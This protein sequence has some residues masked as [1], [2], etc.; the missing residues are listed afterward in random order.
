M[1]QRVVVDTSAIVSI[2][3]EK[4]NLEQQLGELMG[5]TTIVVP[6]AVRD[7]LSLMKSSASRA[8]LELSRRYESFECKKRG[9]EGVIEAAAGS[10]ANAV[11]TNDSILADRLVL[12]GM[13]VLR[14]KGRKKFGFYR[15]DDV[16]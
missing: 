4:V 6:S 12:M 14:L 9:D 5:E 8:A 11:V 3:E 16:Q 13:K 2:F 7:E 1:R 10:N 15:S